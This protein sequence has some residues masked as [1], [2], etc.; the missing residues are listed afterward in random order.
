MATPSVCLCTRVVAVL[1][2]LP[3]RGVWPY[4]QQLVIAS[5]ATARATLPSESESSREIVA[6]VCRKPLLF[7]SL[8]RFAP[9]VVGHAPLFAPGREPIDASTW[10][11]SE[12]SLSHRKCQPAGMRSSKSPRDQNELHFVRP[13]KPACTYGSRSVR[14][15]MSDFSSASEN[16]VSGRPRTGTRLAKQARRSTLCAVSNVDGQGGLL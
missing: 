3:A 9:L 7:P 4:R 10:V 16:A 12:I 1:E 8:G 11:R 14:E 5:P 2:R 15:V 13:E 6:R